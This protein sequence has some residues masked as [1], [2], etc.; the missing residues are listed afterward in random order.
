MG[1]FVWILAG[2][3]AVGLAAAAWRAQRQRVL[4]V[5]QSLLQATENGDVN[6][7]RE[8]LAAGASVK[9]RNDRG[10][11]PLHIAAAGGDVAVAEVLL[12]HGAEVNAR[13]NIGTTPLYNA[14]QFG[15]KEAVVALLLR[16]GADPASAWHSTW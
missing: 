6:A 5:N 13:S 11:T 9:A 15:A 10:L 3:V 12:H 8:L 1:P 16:Y 4:A 2:V 7:M 14:T